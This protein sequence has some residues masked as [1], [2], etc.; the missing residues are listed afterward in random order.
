[1]NISN[2]LISSDTNLYKTKSSLGQQFLDSLLGKIKDD[3]EEDDEK[4]EAKNNTIQEENAVTQSNA[5]I[6]S[7]KDLE[8]DWV[9]YEL[10]IPPGTSEYVYARATD[11]DGNVIFDGN[12]FLNDIDP[13]TATDLEKDVL[14]FYKD[15]QMNKNYMQLASNT[16][17]EKNYISQNKTNIEDKNETVRYEYTSNSQKQYSPINKLEKSINEKEKLG[18]QNGVQYVDSSKSN[19]RAPVFKPNTP[20]YIKQAYYELSYNNYFAS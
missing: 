19:Y 4:D 13:K 18:E 16:N 20:A 9:E 15:Y 11:K 17:Y 7:I 6:S 8:V 10:S 12:I 5:N 14:Q 1:M 2:S 3:D